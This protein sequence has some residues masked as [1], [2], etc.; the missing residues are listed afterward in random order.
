MA[1]T[2]D[3]KTE[4]YFKIVKRLRAKLYDEISNEDLKFYYSYTP[5]INQAKINEYIEA[6]KAASKDPKNF[7]V[8][9]DLTADALV[10]VGRMIQSDPI[11]KE[12][13]LQVA[14]ADEAG[15]ISEKLATGI[16]LVLGGTDIAASINQ[17]RT[18]NSALR[19]SR[20][21]GRP[22]VP[23]R[24]LYLQQALRSAEEG[25]MDAGRALAPVQAQIQDTYLSDI[26]AAKT[27]STGQAGAYNANRQLAYNRKNRAALDLAPIQDS[28]RAREQQRYDN[29]LGMRQNETQQMFQN[30]ASLYGADL[31]QYNREQDLKQLVGATGRLNLRD[32][33][34]K[35]GTQVAN[36]IG[37]YYS[38]QKYR[39]LRNQAE[40]AGLNSD[41][42]IKV[43]QNLDQYV[44][45]PTP[46]YYEQAYIH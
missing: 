31:D 40:A 16:N 23:Q 36:S 14:Q 18:S 22:A 4:R 29:L 12:Q 17:I 43:R 33:M 44:G 39:S 27:A 15:K 35:F 38:N 11:L 26:Q 24:D 6:Q 34:Y 5:E 42:I 32:S 37:D 1:K 25:T 28:I 2:V 20:K 41:N 10:E 8:D 21:P 13:T 45:N 7:V 3:P 19:K 46:Q 30:Q 9:S